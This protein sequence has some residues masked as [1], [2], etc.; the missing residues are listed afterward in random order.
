M[1]GV[2]SEEAPV[3]IGLNDSTRLGGGLVVM[4]PHRRRTPHSGHVCTVTRELSP[5]WPSLA[6]ANSIATASSFPRAACDSRAR[7]GPAATVS[8]LG[9]WDFR[10]SGDFSRGAVTGPSGARVRGCERGGE[11]LLMCRW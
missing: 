4:A 7:P 9:R 1:R 5:M 3:D 10:A 11:R 8:A 6:L 2:Y